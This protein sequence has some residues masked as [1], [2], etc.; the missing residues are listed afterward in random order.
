MA[1]HFA[2]PIGANHLNVIIYQAY[3]FTISL[4]NSIIINCALF[5]F[6]IRTNNYW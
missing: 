4:F 6:R 3:N 1:N 5:Y 2:Q